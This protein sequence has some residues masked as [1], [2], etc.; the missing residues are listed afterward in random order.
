MI[1]IRAFIGVDFDSDCK[2]YICDLQQR[3][4]K[5]AVKGRWKHIDNFHLTL[6]FLDEISVT[7]IKQIDETMRSICA[8]QKLFRLEI[9]EP[10][11][12]GGKDAARVLWLGLAGEVDILGHLAERI[13]KSFHK[14]GFPL[15]KR[16]Y[17]PHVTIGQDIVFECPFGRIRDS[18][19][20]TR[21][22]PVIVNKL[23][24]FKSEQLQNKR[25]YTPISEYALKP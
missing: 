20:C 2:K 3:F 18:I 22:S 23:I 9:T 24:L 19:G 21:Y 17:T 6:K 4:R 13:D 8:G 10:G 14:I 25:V 1:T 12:F 16:R 11:I 7:Q 5:Y 15:E